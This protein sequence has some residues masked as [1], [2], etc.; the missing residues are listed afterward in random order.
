MWLGLWML[1]QWA[2]GQTTAVTLVADSAGWSLMRHGVQHE[3]LGAG[4]KA[5]FGLEEVGPI[6]F[7]CGVQTNRRWFRTLTRDVSHA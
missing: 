4:A 5:H 2:Q 6:P 1:S 3:I 7:G